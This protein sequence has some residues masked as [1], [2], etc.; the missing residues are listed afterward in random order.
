MTSLPSHHAW[1]TPQPMRAPL[2]SPSN[3]PPSRPGKTRTATRA[4][5]C[6]ATTSFIATRTGVLPTVH[7]TS[8]PEVAA[9]ASNYTPMDTTHL[10]TEASLSDVNFS[11]IEPPIENQTEIPVTS[12]VTSFQSLLM[13]Q[14]AQLASTLRTCQLVASLLT[15]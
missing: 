7:V 2:Q 14:K 13:Q 12:I 5:G 10:D 3:K 11:T 1:T 6:T 15:L 9:T 8:A 4:S